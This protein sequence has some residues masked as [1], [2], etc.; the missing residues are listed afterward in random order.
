VLAA[1]DFKKPILGTHFRSETGKLYCFDRT[2]VAVLLGWPKP[3][4]WKKS[5][6][7]PAWFHFRPKIDIP[8]G[9]LTEEDRS[10]YAPTNP[11]WTPSDRVPLHPCEM[12][13]LRWHRT[14]PRDVR[15][16]ICRFS[17]RHWHMLAFIARCGK[18]AFDLAV[19]NPALAYA[20]AS[21]WVFHS[22]A[23]KRP[24]RSARALLAPGRS[25]RDI[26]EW[27]GFPRT[28]AARKMLAKMAP[29][30][31]G[32]EAL[33]YLRQ[34]MGDAGTLKLLSHLPRINAGALRLATDP[35]LVTLAAP[36]LL[37]QV[38]LNPADDER[39]VSGFMLRDCAGMWHAL[40]PDRNPRSIA[41]LDRLTDLHEELIEEVNK[42]RPPRPRIP[43]P[44]PPL[45]GTP[46]IVPLTNS[47]ELEK[48]R[49]AQRN[50]V[51]YYA[52]RIATG[53]HVYIYRVLAPERATLS[54][55][56][57]SGRWVQEELSLKGNAKPSEQ[58]K[59][60][61][62]SWL[63]NYDLPTTTCQTHLSRDKKT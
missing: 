21:N 39:A 14:I 1:P 48:E 51:A 17:S 55:V 28:E 12:S 20:L 25:Q 41:R 47:E 54:V 15:E 59:N 36:S 35:R 24:L 29:K 58:T 4:A 50:C 22:P 26:L 61:V 5:S 43:F 11:R 30:S 63:A 34:G 44:E 6:R 46:E 49:R 10:Q 45:P 33:L 2:S 32:I 53:E 52:D 60:A 23:V 37:E 56:L 9:A 62:R 42:R 19:S 13:W 40:H 57:K 8:G 27:L 16:V 3:R 18:P 31:V 7:K 38:A